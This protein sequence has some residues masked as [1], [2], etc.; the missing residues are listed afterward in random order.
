MQESH[1]DALE[2]AQAEVAALSETKE[3]LQSCLKEREGSIQEQVEQ[4]AALES[5][6]AEL[7]SQLG[8][9]QETLLFFQQF[10][11]VYSP[12]LLSHRCCIHYS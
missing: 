8:K 1:R 4:L 7:K 11:F 5:E 10:P 6:L 12:L 3:N 2:A 9:C